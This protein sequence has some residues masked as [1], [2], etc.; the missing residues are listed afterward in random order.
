MT[1][2]IFSNTLKR[3]IE[4]TE[5]EYKAILRDREN[6]SWAD[7]WDYKKPYCSCCCSDEEFIKQKMKAIEQ[8]TQE[9]VK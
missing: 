4:V 5:L 7:Y 9:K 8:A 2:F 1:Y 3:P 6:Y